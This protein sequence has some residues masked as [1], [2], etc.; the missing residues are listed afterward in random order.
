MRSAKK[1]FTNSSKQIRDSIGKER[2][3]LVTRKLEHVSEERTVQLMVEQ[4]RLDQ[5]QKTS[6]DSPLLA[7]L[8][9]C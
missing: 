3:A 5:H 7:D 6:F 8:L 4:V 9:S 2:L 1:T